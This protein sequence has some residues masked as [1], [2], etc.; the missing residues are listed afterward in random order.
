MGIFGTIDL[1]SGPFGNNTDP[2]KKHSSAQPSPVQQPS[3]S[4]KRNASR[5]KVA[6]KTGMRNDSAPPVTNTIISGPGDEGE[7]GDGFTEHF[8]DQFGRVEAPLSDS[9]AK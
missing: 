5:E 9:D 7:L 1:S 6:E 3:V 4:R 8:S 2:H